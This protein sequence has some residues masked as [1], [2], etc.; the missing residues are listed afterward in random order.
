MYSDSAVIRAI[1]VCNLLD[2]KIGK[3]EYM[4]TEPVCDLTVQS[5]MGSV[6]LEA[7][8][9]GGETFSFFFMSEFSFIE[10]RTQKSVLSV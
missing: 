10:H 4:I 6:W 7:T 9:V 5:C 1:S 3:F 8:H 2:Q